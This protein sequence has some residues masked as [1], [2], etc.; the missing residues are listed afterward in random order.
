MSGGWG[1]RRTD[2]LPGL[3]TGEDVSGGFHARP[4]PVTLLDADGNTLEELVRQPH[5]PQS[6]QLGDLF[7]DTL[8]PRLAGVGPQPV[9]QRGPV[10]LL[11][12]VLGGDGGPQQLL[13]SLD[14]SRVQAGKDQ[15]TQPGLEG[16]FGGGEI[17]LQSSI[18]GRL[19]PGIPQVVH[20][21]GF[22]QVGALFP[23]QDVFA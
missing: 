8:Q 18:R 9:D 4:L 6:S 12:V 14:P 16:A 2:I 1:R 11:R 3:K 10:H 7:L 21:Q 15:L 20:R 5:G 22:E 13:Q 17:A 23:W 19:D